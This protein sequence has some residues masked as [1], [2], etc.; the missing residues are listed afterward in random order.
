MTIAPTSF[1]YGLPATRPVT[2]AIYPFTQRIPAAVVAVFR[3]S[4]SPFKVTA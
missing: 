1:R 3:A 4:P 2:N